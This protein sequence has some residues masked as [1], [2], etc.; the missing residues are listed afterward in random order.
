MSE[1]VFS[2][3]GKLTVTFEPSVHA[4]IDTWTSYGVSVDQFRDAVLVHGLKHAKAHRGHAWIVDSSTAHGAFSQEIQACIGAEVFPAFARS[5]IKF[6][7]TIVSK[8]AVTNMSIKDYTSKLGPN[9]IQ[10]VEV[11][12]VALGIEWLKHH[13]G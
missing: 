10:L 6:F 11:P 9:G 3:P 13:G 12:S 8:S 4:I 7:L 1:Q 2:I 5:G